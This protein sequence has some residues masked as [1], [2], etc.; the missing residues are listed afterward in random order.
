MEKSAAFSCWTVGENVWPPSL[1]A[2]NGGAG[3]RG[4]WQAAGRRAGRVGEWVEGWREGWFTELGE[5]EEGEGKGRRGRN[6][7]GGEWRRVQLARAL[8]RGEGRHGEGGRGGPPRLLVLDE[9]TL[10]MSDEEARRFMEG[11]RATM[12]EE[13][14]EP[15]VVIA[16]QRPSLGRYV[17]QIL[18]LQ[19][20]RIIQQ[21]PPSLVLPSPYLG[22]REGA[23]REGA[24]MAV[25]AHGSGGGGEGRR[26]QG[27]DRGGRR[28]GRP[29]LGWGGGSTS[30]NSDGEDII[31]MFDR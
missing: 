5:G 26:S 10:L 13:W 15:V 19:E 8:A 29:T 21:G 24:A 2:L 20:G 28:G 14:E 25:P 7:S 31:Y 18:V 27:S 6:L 17:D 1:R 22:E 12:R 3:D 23:G 11:L 4:I 16:S 30:S 9:P